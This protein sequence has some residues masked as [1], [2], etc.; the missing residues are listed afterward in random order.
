M[1]RYSFSLDP[2]SAPVPEAETEGSTVSYK[3]PDGLSMPT[4]MSHTIRTDSSL[5]S[6]FFC[7]RSFEP[8]CRRRDQGR[9]GRPSFGSFLGRKKRTETNGYEI[10]ERWLSIAYTNA[11]IFP[12]PLSARP[13]SGAKRAP[14]SP[15][16][17]ALTAGG[18]GTRSWNSL[19]A[20]TAEAADSSA[21]A[22]RR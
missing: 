11:E 3:F 4:S 17:S 7:G 12:L 10:L 5:S 18:F 20:Q 13:E 22:G 9:V 2:S 16:V 1:N 6:A 8:S 21:W 14:A 19:G 15:S